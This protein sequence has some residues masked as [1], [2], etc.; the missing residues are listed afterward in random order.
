MARK[1]HL[2]SGMKTSKLFLP[3]LLLASLV[4]AFAAG[5]P[6][7]AKELALMVRMNFSQQDIL[8]EVGARKLAQPLDAETETVLRTQGAGD[9]LITALKSPAFLLSAE[10]RA[11]TVSAPVQ[12]PQPPPARNARQMPPTEQAAAIQKFLASPYPTS[13]KMLQKLR[14]K[15]VCFRDGDLR[16]FDDYALKNVRWFA[17]YFS[18][19]WCGPCKKFTPQLVEYYNKMKVQYPQFEVVFVSR[20]RSLMAMKGYMEEMKMP[21]PAMQWKVSD[22]DV[23]AVAGDSIPSLVVFDETGRAISVTHR[24]GQYVGPEAVLKDLTTVLKAAAEARGQGRP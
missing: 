17:F 15:L 12:Q 22:P 6:V 18:A 2:S 9:G 20:D 13:D 4:N 19:H 3:L 21:W 7:A 24:N 5:Q 10:E 1:L 11:R 23:E 16:G 8:R 14:G